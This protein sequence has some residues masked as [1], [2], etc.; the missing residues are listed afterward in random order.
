MSEPGKLES[1]L[2]ELV[3]L[4]AARIA[5]SLSKHPQATQSLLRPRLLTVKQAAVYLGRSEKAVYHMAKRGAFPIVQTEACGRVMFD[6]QD[7]DR[8]IEENKDGRE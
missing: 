3:E 2:I 4:L 7:L 1:M 8:W 6:V 5:T